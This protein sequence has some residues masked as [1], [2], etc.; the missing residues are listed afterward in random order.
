MFAIYNKGSVGFRST[1]DNLYELKN[2]DAPNRVSLKPDDDDTFQEY[3]P[4]KKQKNEGNQNQA[5]D[6]YKKMANIDIKEQIFHVR[7]IMTKNPVSIQNTMTLNDSYE[8]LKDSK[9]NQIPI[10]DENQRIIGIINKKMIINLIMDDISDARNTLNKI[11][12]SLYF[13]DVLTTDPITDIRRVAQ[14]MIDFKL[15]AIPVV[16][17]NDNLVG[18]VSKTDIIKAVSNIPKLQLWS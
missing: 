6:T 10:L 1:V 3:M 7:D 11:L 9:V 16:D 13:E 18:I 17:E 12:D 14:V 8:K 15:D 5:I 4:S 2:I